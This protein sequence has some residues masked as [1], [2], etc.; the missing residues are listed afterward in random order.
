MYRDGNALK[1]LITLL[2]GSLL[3]IST[4][5]HASD[6]GV[7]QQ[8]NGI[9][10]TFVESYVS[11]DSEALHQLY[12]ANACMMTVSA[13]REF[14]HGREE[15]IAAIEE[16]FDKIRERDA[17]IDIDFRVVNRHHEGEVVT[18]AGYYLMRF[19]PHA[20]SEQPSSE[21][22]GKFVMNFKK[23]E[24]GSWQV[25]MDSSN[26]SK[27]DL[28]FSAQKAPELYFSEVPETN[29]ISSTQ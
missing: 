16:W 14:I 18:D 9:Y 6:N 10:D 3:W 19:T 1:A 11:L 4:A 2:C 5:G 13:D 17:S 23:N 21:F 28:Y 15:I 24:Q 8:I 12:S 27:P 20:E 7:N 25:F 29:N 26:R 22:A